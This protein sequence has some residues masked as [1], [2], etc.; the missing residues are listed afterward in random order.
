[1]SVTWQEE[2]I[3]NLFLYRTMSLGHEFLY[4]VIATHFGEADVNV[5]SENTSTLDV[6]LAYVEML[7]LQVIFSWIAGLFFRILS[8][9]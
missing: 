6:S 2:K 1:M 3:I 5:L 4:F 9:I 8:P 7:L